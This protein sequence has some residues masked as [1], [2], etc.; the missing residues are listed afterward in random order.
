MSRLQP[1]LDKLE[2]LQALQ[3]RSDI[4]EVV[5]FIMREFVS[6]FWDL[7]ASEK[8]HH[9]GRWG[10]L[11]HS[12]DTA[13]KRAENVASRVAVDSYGNPSAEAGRKHRGEQIL[14]SW[15]A[16]MLHDG[17][18][19]FDVDIVAAGKTEEI[20]FHPLRGN[21]LSFKLTH[22]N[23]VELRWKKGRGMGHQRYNL[24]MIM[25]LLGWDFLRQ[26]EPDQLIMLFDEL[27]RDGDEA[28][29]ESV[30]EDRQAEDR[31]YVSE[32]IKLFADDGFK[33]KDKKGNSQCRVFALGQN[34]YALINPLVFEAISQYARKLGGDYS[35][36]QVIQYL[37]NNRHIY[38]SKGVSSGHYFIKVSGYINNNAVQFHIVFASGD[39]FA[40]ADTSRLPGFKL[41]YDEETAEKIKEIVGFDPPAEW[42]HNPPDGGS[43][44]DGTP[45][46][47]RKD[48]QETQDESNA[49]TISDVLEQSGPEH[50]DQEYQPNQ[51]TVEQS[52][53]AGPEHSD[54][55][56]QTAKQKSTTQSGND[57]R[58]VAILQN[59]ANCLE[60][61]DVVVN[62]PESNR[63]VGYISETDGY[64]WV[65]TDS[66]SGKP[67]IPDELINKSLAEIVS[68]L[69]QFGCVVPDESGQV[70]IAS[71]TRFEGEKDLLKSPEAKYVRL[72]VDK[73]DELV[74][75]SNN[76][77]G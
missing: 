38:S 65:Q 76:L 74:P 49:D 62:D 25:I 59:L 13:L 1:Y 77:G 22:P 7:P 72:D 53:Q 2:T 4:I 16:G 61:G 58:G 63:N 48:T 44:Q 60:Q 41:D 68:I 54:P 35:K 47:Q 36:D 27:S 24:A 21:I 30:A 12:L 55:D 26:L 56:Q 71:F 50:S 73:L 5:R 40:D 29:R 66:L 17:G 46:A 11:Y 14:I 52:E 42:F 34:T 8:F 10:L 70:T 75:L 19:M 33:A 6:Y 15:I 67:V 39:M 9:S 37:I 57:S 3:G 69:H 64:L 20:F 32:A 28:D 31:Q 43:E 45:Q 51:Q 18:K 23:N